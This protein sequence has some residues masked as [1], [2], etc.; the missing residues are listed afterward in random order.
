M[1][2]MYNPPHPGE[3]LRDA[4]DGLPMTVTDFAAHIGVAR[5]TVNRVLSGKAGITPD[6]SIRLSQAFNQPTQ[7]IWLKMQMDYEFW[8]AS[9]AKRKPVKPLRVAA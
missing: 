7:D 9:Q 6:M 8:Q 1:A 4:L 5:S 2:R 3:I